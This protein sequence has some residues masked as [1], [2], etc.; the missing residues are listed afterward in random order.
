MDRQTDGVARAGAEQY[1]DADATLELFEALVDELVERLQGHDDWG[2]SGLRRSQYSHD[3]VAD[4]AMLGGLHRAGFSVLSEE[5]GLTGNGSVMVVVDP[6]DGSTNAALGLPWF[7]A[8]LCAVD[9]TG[10][11]V[12]VVANLASGERYRAVRGRGFQRVSGVAEGAGTGGVVD[13]LARPGLGPSSCRDLGDAVI[14]L[15]GL[16]P[17][18]GGWRQFRVYGAAAL[19]LCAVA[20]GRLDGYVDV[21]RAHGAWDYMGAYLVCSEAGVA[22]VDSGGEELVVLDHDARRGPIAAATPELLEQLVT[23]ERSWR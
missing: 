22:M 10:P 19:D 5:S 11:W 16:A 1:R 15:S 9:E 20:V 8:S 18:Y 12:A 7:A 14:G 21:N 13:R 17:A 3:V 4:E 2:P 23:M 6:V